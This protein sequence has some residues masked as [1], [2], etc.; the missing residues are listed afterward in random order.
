MYTSRPIKVG[1]GKDFLPNT[2]MQSLLDCHK[3]ETDPRSRD[4]LLAYM[5]RKDGKTLRVIARNTGRGMAT[6]FRWLE[7]A[8][9]EGIRARYE[10]EGR[11]RK[12]LL[13]ESQKKQLISDLESGPEACGFENSHWSSM[14]VR[15]HIHNKFGVKY[16]KGGVLTLLAGLGF[17]WP[18]T[19]PKN[20]KSVSKRK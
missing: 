3:K 17:R 10:R 4:R 11:G 8:Q 18:K 14:L 19:R 6:I 16:T 9:N 15:V 1:S 7:R 5:Q 2:S 20:P 13:D 12:S